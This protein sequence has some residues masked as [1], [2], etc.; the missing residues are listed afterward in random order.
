MLPSAPEPSP[1]TSVR[2]SLR[3]GP[4]L[5]AIADAVPRGARVADIGTD[6]AM[7]LAWLDHRGRIERG[8]GIDVADGALAQAHRTLG[9]PL[10]PNLELR[11]G[12]GLS[13]LEP[14]EVDTV[15]LAGMGGATMM[16]LVDAAPA[17]LPSLRHLVLQPNTEWTAVRRWLADHRWPLLDE[18]I[19]QDRRKFYVVLVVDPHPGPAPGWDEDALALGPHLLRARPPGFERWLAEEV[20]RTD[21]ALRGARSGRGPHTD[22]RIDA[23]LERRARLSRALGHCATSAE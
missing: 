13:P 17:V 20:E 4:R 7:L 3:F 9:V 16:R 19:V 21:R 1:M 8:I 23:L 5:Q 18:R 2:P 14:G 22:G 6:H 11:H 12:D 15:V 10:P